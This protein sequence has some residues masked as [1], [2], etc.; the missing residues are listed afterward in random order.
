MYFGIGL[1]VGLVIGLIMHVIFSRK[2]KT[3]GSFIMD[4]SD[5]LKD[6]CRLDLTEDL[7]S[8]YGKK[9]IV[10]AVETHEDDSQ[11]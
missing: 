10:L 5:P 4:F 8:I 7:N 2:P 11:V 1:I 3:S 6:V 9:Y